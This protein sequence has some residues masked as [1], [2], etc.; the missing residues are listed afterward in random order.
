MPARIIGLKNSGRLVPGY[1]ADF[2]ILDRDIF[3]I[4]PESIGQ[5]EVAAT[6]YRGEKVYQR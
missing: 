1:Y 3:N 6:Y 5:T 2:L 4:E